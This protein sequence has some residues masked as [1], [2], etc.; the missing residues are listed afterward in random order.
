M[1]QSTGPSVAAGPIDGIPDPWRV[2]PGTTASGPGPAPLNCRRAELLPPIEREVCAARYAAAETRLG[3]RRLSRSESRRE[4][5]FVEQAAANE[6]WAAYRRSED[7]GES[8]PGLRSMLKH[9]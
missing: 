1:P 8:Y 2:R 4:S 7:D 3:Q 9:F 5:G 6:A